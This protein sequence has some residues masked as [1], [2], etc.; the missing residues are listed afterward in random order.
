M[1]NIL[2][3][4]R[5]LIV[6]SYWLMDCIKW[7]I[8]P[9][10][11]IRKKEDLPLTIG[12]TTFA[13]RFKG[14]LIPLIKKL[15]AM[16]PKAQLLVLANGDVDEDK[17][18]KYLTELR[19]FCAAYHNLELYDHLQPVGL[20]KL[21]N[22]ILLKAKHERVLLLNDD[23]QIGVNFANFL[24][25]SGILGEEIATI[26]GSWSHFLINKSLF[27]KVGYFDERLQEI[28]GEDDD[29]AARCALLGIKIEDYDTKAIGAKR[30]RRSRKIKVN[31]WGKDM[32]QQQSGY[33]TL[34]H[35]FL[36]RKW[37]TSDKPFEGATFVPNRTPK[38]WKLRPGME[39]PEFP[40]KGD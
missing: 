8:V 5:K 16:F 31:S 33:S 26:R 9:R 11:F 29:Y 40:P 30:R 3:L 1:R 21:W 18:A 14:C 39:T 7:M 4:P 17:Q 15:H 38:F 20:S 37:E 25:L 35:D 10:K 36:T 34:N 13:D 32:S 24:G 6:T 28:S 2:K 12:V 23:I 22:T 19:E 27:N